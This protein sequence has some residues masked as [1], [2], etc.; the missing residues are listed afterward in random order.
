MKRFLLLNVFLLLTS[1]ASLFNSPY[2]EIQLKTNVPTRVVVLEDSLSTPTKVHSFTVKRSEEPLAVSIATDSLSRKIDIRPFNSFAYASNFFNPSLWTLGFWLI[3]RN[4]PKRYG[5]PT[6]VSVDLNNPLQEYMDYDAFKSTEQLLKVTPLKLLALHNASLELAY[7]RTTGDDFSTQ[8][9]ISWLLPSSLSNYDIDPSPQTKGFRLALEE[10]FYFKK[11][12]PFGPYFALE[13]DYLDR[14]SY[15]KREFAPNQEGIDP[16]DY[17]E[18]SYEDTFIVNAIYLSR[19]FK[20][21][22]QKEFSSVFLD[23]YIGLGVRTRTISHSER[24]NPEDVMLSYSHFNI[25]YNRIKEG[26]ST[27]L[28]L[29][30]NARIGWR[31]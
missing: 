12:A 4:S 9:M 29:P 19:N 17:Y 27:V 8:L 28:S 14:Y 13:L 18:D 24:I 1:C 3:D 7:E 20:F 10:R 5:Y 15:T 6:L 30:L 26:K 31:F 11:K 25:E 2:Q 21:G 23:V 16:F 22:Y